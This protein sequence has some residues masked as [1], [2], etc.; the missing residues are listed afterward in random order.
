VENLAEMAALGLGLPRETFKDA[1]RYG[2]VDTYQQRLELALT[3]ASARTFSPL[4]HPI[5]KSTDPKT[6]FSLASIPISTS[7]QFTA[8][9]DT[10]DFTYGRE[11]LENVSPLSSPKPQL[12]TLVDIYSCKPEN[13]WSTCQAV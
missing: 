1:G 5:S 13:S 7:L 8:V 11:I 9:H 4:L 12:R 10:P 3:T 6:R 2:Y